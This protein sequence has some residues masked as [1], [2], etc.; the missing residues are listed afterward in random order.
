MAAAWEVEYDDH[1][2]R[3]TF[4]NSFRFHR[5]VCNMIILGLTVY[6]A[7]TQARA[8]ITFAGSL[9]HVMMRDSKSLPP[10]INI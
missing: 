5:L 10:D 9:W 1:P 3:G 8:A 6:R 2:F 7:F 4:T